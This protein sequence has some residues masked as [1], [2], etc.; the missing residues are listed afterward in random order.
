MFFSEFGPWSALRNL[1]ALSQVY[2]ANVVGAVLY[3][4]YLLAKIVH[5]LRSPEGGSR[6]AAIIQKRYWQLVAIQSFAIVL[7]SGCI[8]SQI[9]GIWF[10]YIARATDA[11]PFAA[12]RE[13]W[14]VF[15]LFIFLHIL[16]DGMRRYAWVIFVS[17]SSTVLQ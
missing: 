12:L 14:I 15:Q 2:F 17:Q 6:Q 3:A 5:A 13:A 10:T 1:D 11:N 7:T 8:A 9:F 16:L 4:I